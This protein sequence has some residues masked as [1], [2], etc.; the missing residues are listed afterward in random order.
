MAGIIHS[1]LRTSMLCMLSI[2]FMLSFPSTA[3]Q[4]HADDVEDEIETLAREKLMSLGPE[5][6]EAFV[7]GLD[8][9][10][11][12]SLQ[13]GI[14]N[15]SAQNLPGCVAPLSDFQTR[16]LSLSGGGT[17]LVVGADFEGGVAF[18]CGEGVDLFDRRQTKFFGAGGWA[19]RVGAAVDA[20]FNIGHWQVPH[21]N[22][23]GRSVG[24]EFELADL[25]KSL[26][27][28]AKYMDWI[29]KENSGSERFPFSIGVTFWWENEA[30]SSWAKPIRGEYQGFVISFVK[31]MG[32]ELGAGLVTSRTVQ[33]CDNDSECTLGLWSDESGDNQVLIRK[34]VFDPDENNLNI[35]LG[36]HYIVAD[37][38][39]D[40]LDLDTSEKT[41]RG[42]P[43]DWSDYRERRDGRTLY[44][45]CFRDNYTKMHL[46]LGGGICN[47]SQKVTL[48]MQRPLEE[49]D[50][51]GRDYRGY[52][53]G[54]QGGTTRYIR[55]VERDAN[56]TLTLQ[57]FG[58]S[59]QRVFT[60]IIGP[61]YTERSTAAMLTVRNDVLRLQ[62]GRSTLE[63]TRNSVED[64]E[65]MLGSDFALADSINGEYWNAIVNGETVY[66]KVVSRSAGRIELSR[67]GE[68]ESRQ[69]I[70]TSPFGN[71]F[72]GTDGVLVVDGARMEL[73][74]AVFRRN[75]IDEDARLAELLMQSRPWPGIGAVVAAED[76]IID[77]VGAWTW[78]SDD[79]LKTNIFVSQTDSEIRLRDRRNPLALHTYQKI[80]PNIY[81]HSSGSTFDFRSETILVWKNSGGDQSI[82]MRRE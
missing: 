52:W 61:T 81:Q 53:N 11:D 72:L 3:F 65:R 55:I 25:L 31:D 59:A 40:Y 60:K 73:N 38:D 39:S 79:T 82:I 57:E 45:I 24:W 62:E 23:R 50:V 70:K 29:E 20:A 9:A 33:F 71:R 41:V 66:D 21:N 76:E 27:A 1:I 34:H 74:G 75:S 35:K 49:S 4:A 78:T 68:N 15:E 28:V 26:R 30:S 77:V 8:A 54:A 67:V 80:A 69:Y 37:I 56:H 36:D 47:N 19:V 13:S 17:L 63:F 18:K 64:D 12:E 46:S 5:L 7:V 2:S 48:T 43:L 16:T 42:Q 51:V 6:F 32:S 44:R 14:K 58:S 10:N 22:L